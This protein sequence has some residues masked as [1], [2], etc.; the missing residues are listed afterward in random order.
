M[1]F[2]MMSILGSAFFGIAMVLALYFHIDLSKVGSWLL[3]ISSTVLAV[4]FTLEWR[5]R[6]KRFSK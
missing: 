5:K 3:I 1:Q 2:G 6:S 4:T